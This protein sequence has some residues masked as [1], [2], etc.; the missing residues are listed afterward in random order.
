MGAMEREKEEMARR[1]ACLMQL[2][3]G[4]L[5]WLH[6]VNVEMCWNQGMGWQG[7]RSY[8]ECSGIAPGWILPLMQQYG[9][10]LQELPLY[11]RES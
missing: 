10:P 7:V 6:K 3:L 4:E 8:M 11:D 2:K 5:Y 9:Y 1:N